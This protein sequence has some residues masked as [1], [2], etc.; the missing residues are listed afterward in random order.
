[1]RP[2]LPAHGTPDSSPPEHTAAISPN[3]RNTRHPARRRTPRR[4]RR[5]TP[6]SERLTAL[7][8]PYKRRAVERHKSRAATPT[9]VRTATRR[10]RGQRLRRY[11]N[12]QETQRGKNQATTRRGWKYS[13]RQSTLK[14]VEDH[15]FTAFRLQSTHVISNSFKRA[16]VGK[17]SATA[18]GGR[19]RLR[20]LSGS[21]TSSPR[22][23]ATAPT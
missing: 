5:A 19:R 6:P 9:L 21:A 1:M 13:Y 12:S 17:A 20:R 7:L 23:S 11:A 8:C 2:H 16:A 14:K 22:S 4:G 10:Q 15:F 3:P 18:T